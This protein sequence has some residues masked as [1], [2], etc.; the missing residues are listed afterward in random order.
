MRTIEHVIV[1]RT[2][3]PVPVP[4][5]DPLMGLVQDR[6]VEVSRPPQ[7]WFR[8]DMTQPWQSE[9]EAAAEVEDR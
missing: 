8:Y 1:N 9:R 4:V 6:I 2:L 3:I 7:P 5:H